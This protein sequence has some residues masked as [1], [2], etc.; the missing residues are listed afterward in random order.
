MLQ[1]ARRYGV[2]TSVTCLSRCYSLTEHELDI[3]DASRGRD[4][5]ILLHNADLGGAEAHEKS[6]RLISGSFHEADLKVAQCFNMR[7][8]FQSQTAI[9]APH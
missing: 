6:L 7:Q 8:S 1:V 5:G 2:V 4:V 9:H 3:G